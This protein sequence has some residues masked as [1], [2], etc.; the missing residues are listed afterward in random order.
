MALVV[1]TCEVKRSEFNTQ[2]AELGHILA[3]QESE[4]GGA[5]QETGGVTHGDAVKQSRPRTA[6]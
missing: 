5:A 6:G 4:V 3:H 2:R 1:D